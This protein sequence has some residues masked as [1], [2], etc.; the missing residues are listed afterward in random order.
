MIT[1]AARASGIGLS[2]NLS[3]GRAQSVAAAGSS[4]AECLTPSR[5]AAASAIVQLAN[6]GGGNGKRRIANGHVRASAPSSAQGAGPAAFLHRRGNVVDSRLTFPITPAHGHGHMHNYNSY[7][8]AYNP[9][10]TQYAPQPA[11]RNDTAA[12]LLTTVKPGRGSGESYDSD[13]EASNASANGN[14]VQKRRR[15]NTSSTTAAASVAG[16]CQASAQT[17]PWVA[18]S[19]E[20]A[21]PPTQG[22]NASAVETTRGDAKRS[23]SVASLTGASKVKKST[24]RKDKSLGVLCERFLLK[25]THEQPQSF[26]LDTVSDSLGVERRRIYDIVN[27]LESINVVSRNGKNCYIWN[28]MTQLCV[29]VFAL[30]LCSYFSLFVSFHT[31]PAL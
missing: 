11:A 16:A 23:H 27:V 8:H 6:F 5:A 25:Y 22:A 21:M 31:N 9:V 2:S 13:D 15:R 10:N 14:P 28:G 29:A 3:D 24:K 7:P 17:P 18:A 20:P 26:S 1:S 30:L 4:V 19:R 12:M